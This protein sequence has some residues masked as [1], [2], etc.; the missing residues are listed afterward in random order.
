MSWRLDYSS[1]F[2]RATKRLVK[3]HPVAVE[4]LQA[5][6]LALQTDPFQAALK[7]HKLK[8]PWKGSWSCSVGYDLRIVFEFVQVNGVEVIRLLNAGTHDEVY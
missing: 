6:L 1:N 3:K 7:S 4:A 8:G 2:I 5:T